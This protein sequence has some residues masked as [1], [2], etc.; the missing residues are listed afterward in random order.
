MGRG[1]EW[2][3]TVGTLEQHVATC[4]FAVVPCPKECKDDNGVQHLMRK[5]LASHL[6]STC[7]NRDYQCQYCEEIISYASIKEHH[8][9]VCKKK[10]L[11]CPNAG[12]SE[13]MQRQHLNEHVCNECAHTVI[14]C[15]YK[16]IGCDKKTEEG[17][18]SST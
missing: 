3:G 7:P 14:A 4:E 10:I 1:C 12:C 13:E 15:K 18:Y 2:E 9:K 17:R 5:D 6:E 16:G 8:N 11:P